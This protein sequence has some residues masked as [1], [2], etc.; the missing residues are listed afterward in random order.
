MKALLLLGSSLLLSS[1]VHAQL[2][3]RAGANVTSLHELFSR[4]S[5]PTTSLAG[6]GYQV[7]LAYE[8]PLGTRWA[9]VPELQFSRESQQLR[10]EGYGFSTYPL[11][12]DEYLIHDYR[13]S[14]S[15]LNL[16]VLVRRYVGPVY[17]EA[18]PQVSLLVG[19]QGE[20]ETRSVGPS[21][22]GIGPYVMVTHQPISQAATAA[23]QRL[24]AAACVGLGM[25]LPGG[26]QAGVRGYW[27]SMR[28][29]PEDPK[30]YQ[31]SPGA[32]PIAGTQF[33]RTLQVLVS[34]QLW[35]KK[36]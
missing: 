25:R 26:W 12:S 17:I 2:S 15:Y 34:R 3:L 27:S 20:G 30:D 31:Y 22:S 11:P 16:P 23:Y 21:M 29:R 4:N 9:V 5:L 14:C 13:L 10:K 18:G 36:A 32:M 8:L 24:N 7:G 6:V 19:G 28:S 35:A 1:A 33:R